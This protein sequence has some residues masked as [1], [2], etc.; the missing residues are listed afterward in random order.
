MTRVEL[1]SCCHVSFDL[2]IIF[3]SLG[4]YRYSY[5]KILVVI[6]TTHFINTFY[7]VYVY[8]LQHWP[9]TLK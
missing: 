6:R 1:L 7:M 9:F 3:P 4:Q 5:E 2:Y 8:L